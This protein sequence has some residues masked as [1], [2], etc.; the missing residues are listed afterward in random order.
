M[1]QHAYLIILS[2]LL[3]PWSL[4]QDT[5]KFSDKLSPI[6]ERNFFE[7]PG[8]A[9]WGGHIVKEND[10]YYLIYSRWKTQGGDW[11]T[12]SEIAIASADRL[13]GPYK[14]IQ[15][16]LQGA[17]NGHWN[18]LMA[19]NPKMKKFGDRW[20]L[21][22]ISSQIGKTR[23]HTRDSQRIG[24]ASSKSILG[25]FT[26]SVEPIVK[27]H[28]PIFNITV[29]PGVTQRPDRT[30]LMILKGDIKPKTSEQ[31]MPQRIQGLATSPTPTG[32]FTILSKPAISDIDTE[33]ASIWYDSTR[34][35]YYAVFHAHKYIGLLTSADG[36]NWKKAADAQIT[37]KTFA[38]VNDQTITVGSIERPYVYL[39][40]GEPKALC[41]S[42]RRKGKGYNHGRCLII[43]LKK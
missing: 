12:S 36:I 20:Y 9:T 30:Y 15:I 19:H 35:R 17:G 42:T 34:R 38:S 31:P 24:V 8:Y 1:Y 4:G 23:Q 41:L 3:S 32:P 21:Y 29:N 27:P 13:E 18:E 25:P 37:G 10:T 26:T 7:E 2:F 16:L 22:F 28:A 11:L 5:L 6:T 39:E 40:N 14:H 33:D 43:P